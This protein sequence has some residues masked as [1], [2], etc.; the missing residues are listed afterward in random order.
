MDRNSNF[1]KH[2][3][4]TKGSAQALWTS[5]FNHWLGTLAR[6]ASQKSLKMCAGEHTQKSYGKII[7]T[8]EK[9]ET[10]QNVHVQQN[11]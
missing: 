8:S 6:N 11:G 4:I 7:H 1:N 3:G 5:N 2:F 9:L 10:I